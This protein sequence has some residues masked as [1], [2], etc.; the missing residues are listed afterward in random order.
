VK[1][2]GFDFVIAKVTQGRFYVDPQWPTFRDSARA[3]GLILLGYHYVTGDAPAAQARN[4]VAAA[5][6]ETVCGAGDCGSHVCLG[7]AAVR[8]TARC[9]A[10][11]FASA[12]SPR[13]SRR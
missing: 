10:A 2:E 6:H 7:R 9:P 8:A 4:F 12:K 13:V 3:N 1:S 5:W 11:R